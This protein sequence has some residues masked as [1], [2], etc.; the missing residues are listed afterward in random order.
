MPLQ[1]KKR[2]NLLSRCIVMTVLTMIVLW[3]VFQGYHTKSMYEKYGMD[4]EV[5]IEG[6]S[7][8]NRRILI[9]G[10][11]VYNNELY[12]NV[13]VTNYY[14]DYGDAIICKVILDNPYKAV[15]IR[16]NSPILGVIMFL[17]A[18][19]WIF[20]YIS[21][22]RVYL[23]FVKILETGILVNG[24]IMRVKEVRKEFFLKVEFLD[25]EGNLQLAEVSMGKRMAVVGRKCSIKYLVEEN[26]IIDAIYY[27]ERRQ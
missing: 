7:T 19:I 22:M 20:V 23:R 8:F 10:K 4:V 15:Y 27:E 2:A 21:V 17:I 18:G 3:S 9:W 24:T 14:G 25:P 12:E 26:G 13:R 6:R 5:R 1:E 11:Y 16:D